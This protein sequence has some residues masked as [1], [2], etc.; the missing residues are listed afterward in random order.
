[1]WERFSL[2]PGRPPPQ[3]GCLISGVS[4]HVDAFVGHG[5][6]HSALEFL[7]EEDTKLW[8][9]LSLIAP[10][11]RNPRLEVRLFHGE[12]DR[13]VPADDAF[14]LHKALT[15][16]GYD[17]RL[18]LVDAGRAIRRSGPAREALIQAI[19]VAAKP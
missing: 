17:A 19:L 5:C 2:S 11:G 12:E 10:I 4:P 8:N 18:T 3:A 13:L 16:A 7:A 6:P 14:Q 9:I 15:D 1:L